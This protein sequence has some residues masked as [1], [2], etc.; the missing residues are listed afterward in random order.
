MRTSCDPALNPFLNAEEKHLFV[1]KRR[2]PMRDGMGI[3]LLGL[4]L[5]IAPISATALGL[6]CS[7]ST[8]GVAFGNYSPINLLPASA[9][10]NVRVFCTVALVSVNAQINI[11]LSPGG[12][13]SFSPRSLSS[14]AN[15]LPY[16]L[17]SDAPTT[18]VWGDGTS[19]TGNVTHN[20]PIAVLGTTVN[21]PVYGKIPAA[22]YVP[23]GSYTDTITVTVE[24]HE[25]L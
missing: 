15:Q 4:V 11:S 5:S 13:G 10:G 23:A 14:G 9:A 1:R 8:T 21:S 16:N 19:G 17:Y 20:L 7:A 2:T 3:R 12:S 6:S 25:A 18:I 22:Q 24:Y